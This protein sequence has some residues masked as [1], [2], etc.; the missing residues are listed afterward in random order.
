[1]RRVYWSVLI[2][3]VILVGGLLLGMS[4]LLLAP[5][6]AVPVILAVLFWL[7]ERKATHQRPVE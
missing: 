7:A 2:A 6:F 3:L 5:V 1:M 4:A